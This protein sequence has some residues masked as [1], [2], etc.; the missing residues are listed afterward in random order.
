MSDTGAGRRV[1]G[2]C[3]GPGHIKVDLEEQKL[4]VWV[5]TQVEA[6]GGQDKVGNQPGLFCSRLKEHVRE[7][8]TEIS[9][10]KTASLYAF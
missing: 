6:I 2:L 4:E 8:N 7:H 5:R 3:T 10:Q 9:R 1:Q